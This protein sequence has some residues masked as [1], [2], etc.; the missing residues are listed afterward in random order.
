MKDNLPDAV[1]RILSPHRLSRWLGGRTH[2]SKRLSLARKP[3]GAGQEKSIFRGP[4]EAGWC[5]LLTV[6]HERVLSLKVDRIFATVDR[7]Q[8]SKKSFAEVKRGIPSFAGL[9]RT[10]DRLGG[11]SANRLLGKYPV[12][13]YKFC[14]PQS[15]MLDC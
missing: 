15:T 1:R 9:Q 6:E 14:V 2:P 5:A 11:N 3:E 8:Q 10:W 4:V 7:C 13:N 12:S